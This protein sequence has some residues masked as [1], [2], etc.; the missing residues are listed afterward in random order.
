MTDSFW[1]LMKA[2]LR[3][4]NLKWLFG[5]ELPVEIA[6]P[7]TC[8]GSGD[9]HRDIE[10]TTGSGAVGSLRLHPAGARGM[11]ALITCLIDT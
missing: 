4:G 6:A 9:L 1:P 5:V 11:A 8:S 10:A 3:S 7:D 2:G